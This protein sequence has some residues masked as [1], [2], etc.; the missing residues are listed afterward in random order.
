MS[1]SLTTY[2]PEIATVTAIALALHYMRSENA[3]PAP[4]MLGV[5]H[6]FLM[7]VVTIWLSH[8]TDR[9]TAFMVLGVVYIPM[10]YEA[11]LQHRRK[12]MD[13]TSDTP[14]GPSASR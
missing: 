9:M 7:L 8:T 1:F 4:P 11:F 2:W 13:G 6:Y 14:T 10:A 3:K 12:R 5:F